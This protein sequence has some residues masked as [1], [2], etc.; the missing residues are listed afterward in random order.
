MRLTMGDLRRLIISEAR[1]SASKT[2]KKPGKKSKAPTEEEIQ[3]RYDQLRKKMSN[4]N[5]RHGYTGEDAFI[6]DGQLWKTAK[7]QL[8]AELA[9]ARSRRRMREAVDLGSHPALGVSRFNPDTNEEDPDEDLLWSIS[10]NVH[11][12]LTRAAVEISELGYDESEMIKVIDYFY[13]DW[14]SGNEVDY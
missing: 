5:K 3:A 4:S 12:A 6:D 13:Q 14:V 11:K 9:E 2:P 7:E 1:A 10:N 8:T